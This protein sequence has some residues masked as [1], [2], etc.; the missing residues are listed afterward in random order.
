[1]RKIELETN[2]I[3]SG[4]ADGKKVYCELGK[5]FSWGNP[6]DSNQKGWVLNRE[7][8]AKIADGIVGNF[9]LALEDTKVKTLGGL[10]GIEVILNSQ[11]NG[12]CLDYR[13]FPWYWDVKTET[14]G[15]ISYGD[16]LAERFVVLNSGIIYL[17]Y[18][19]SA[20]PNY[21]GFIKDMIFGNW[22]QILIQYRIG[23]KDLPVV[24]AYLMS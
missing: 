19:I 8:R 17:K 15:Y 10:G 16:L 5:A 9:I 20:H 23:I 1:M 18:D 7:I 12:F 22:G 21:I 6:D 14:G 4:V 2:I 3:P 13:S 11:N 24:N